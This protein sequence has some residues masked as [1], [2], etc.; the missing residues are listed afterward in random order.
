MNGSIAAKFPKGEIIAPAGCLGCE[1]QLLEGYVLRGIVGCL[2]GVPPHQQIKMPE[3]K[4]APPTINIEIN[5]DECK[6]CKIDMCVA[7]EH[8]LPRAVHEF[9]KQHIENIR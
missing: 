5:M 3:L 4:V 6:E 7:C 2:D 1:I 8:P 9:M